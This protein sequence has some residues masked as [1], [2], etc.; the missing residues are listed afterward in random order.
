MKTVLYFRVSS[1]EQA[2]EGFSLPAQLNLLRTYAKEHSLEIVEEVLEIET[3][4]KP[5]R[6]SFGDMVS[7]LKEHP[8]VRALLVEKTDRLYRNF[9]DY[10]TI[11]EYVQQ[12][13][14]VHLVKE[15]AV[16]HKDS[17]SHEKLVHE[18]KVVIAKNFIDNLSEETRKGQREKA[19]Q[20]ILPGWAPIGYLNNTQTKTIEIDP[21][22]APKVQRLFR[23][24]A[25]GQ[26]S[27]KQLARIAAEIGLGA[28][29]LGRKLSKSHIHRLLQNPFY[30]GQFWLRGVVYDGKHLPL[31]S[32]QLFDAVQDALHQRQRPKKLVHNFPFGG[33]LTC[34]RC[35]CAIVGEIQ[36]GRYVYYHCTYGRGRC[37][38]PFVREES[39]SEQLGKVV[40]ALEIPSAAFKWLKEVLAERQGD[41]MAERQTRIAGSTQRHNQLRQYRDRLYEDKLNG[42]I[43]EAFWQEK[44]NAYSVELATTVEQLE[45]LKQNEGPSPEYGLRA[46]ELTQRLYPLYLTKPPHEKKELLKILLS[47][48]IFDG[49]TPI[50]TYRSPFDLIAQGA[51]NKDWGG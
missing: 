22:R 16:L 40:Q 45:R 6:S 36:K 7:Y 24:A 34:A 43:S 27:V 51:K 21:D 50:P 20:G 32:K 44:H 46:L 42:K 3:A 31:I 8:D 41:W 49:V 23:L 35:G 14:A 30:Y 15:G 48:C 11:D 26:Y 2:K 37:G 39:L 12:G 28:R 19:S 29:K 9:K 5:G 47:N 18:I 25:T 1:E 33:F 38:S 13:L 17:S 10:V 4:K